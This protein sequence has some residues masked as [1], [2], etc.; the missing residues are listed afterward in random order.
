[1]DIL[2]T[3][4]LNS[5]GTNP[6]FW[7]WAPHSSTANL[8]VQAVTMK[9]SLLFP[10]S[11]LN[12]IAPSTLWLSALSSVL[13]KFIH[14]RMPSFCF[15]L[16]VCLCHTIP[17]SP[18]CCF[19]FYLCLGLCVCS[20]CRDQPRVLMYSASALQLFELFIVNWGHIFSASQSS[21]LCLP[22]R[23]DSKDGQDAQACYECWD[24]NS[25]LP[26]WE[27]SILSCRGISY[28]IKGLFL[29]G[30]TK[31]CFEH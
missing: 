8:Q 13:F 27:A 4:T 29:L 22:R 7:V 5:H 20:V 31:L 14:G 6:D 12:K 30:E 21:C 17:S 24:L 23:W 2:P 26:D 16:Q 10:P 18:L 25:S 9:Y 19:A 1:M 3:V 28:N 15:S 11:H